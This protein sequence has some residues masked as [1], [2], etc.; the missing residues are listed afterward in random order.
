MFAIS[1][2][3]DAINRRTMSMIGKHGLPRSRGP[4]LYCPIAAG[5]G[6]I[7]A[8]RRPGD[9]INRVSMSLIGQH[10]SACE[11]IPHLYCL[12]LSCG[13]DTF[14]V[15]RPGQAMHT[16]KTMTGILE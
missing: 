11:S 14:T 16:G 12:I 2:P 6:E 1:T 9:C 7:C 10:K 3:G 15:W 4:H 8:I 13:G 5:R